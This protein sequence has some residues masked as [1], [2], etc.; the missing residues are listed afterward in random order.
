MDFIINTANYNLT[1]EKTSRAL[2]ARLMYFI[3]RQYR[4]NHSGYNHSHNNC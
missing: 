1:E 2:I 4:N 3:Y